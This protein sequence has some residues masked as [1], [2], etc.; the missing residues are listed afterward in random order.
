MF[1]I[2]KYVVLTFIFIMLFY[3][4]LYWGGKGYTFL[5]AVEIF[6]YRDALP[7]LCVIVICFVLFKSSFFNKIVKK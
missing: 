6:Y 2:V 5:K 7:A 1:K 3:V 4:I